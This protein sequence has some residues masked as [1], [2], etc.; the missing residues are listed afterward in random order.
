MDE[1]CGDVIK[2]VSLKNK[3]QNNHAI[4]DYIAQAILDNENFFSI[5]IIV[6]SISPQ[7]HDTQYYYPV[8]PCIKEFCTVI[9][10]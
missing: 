7:Y 1:I 4:D 6:T 5:Y 9:Y 10:H 2:F 3:P 8:K